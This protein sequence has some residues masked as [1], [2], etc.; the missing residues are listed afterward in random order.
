M[1]RRIKNLW[2]LSGVDL[3]HKLPDKIPARIALGFDEKDYV[4][5]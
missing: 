2:K 3:T 1:F 4:C 5:G